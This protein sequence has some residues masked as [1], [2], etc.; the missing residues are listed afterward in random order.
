MIKFENI[1]KSYNGKV[2]CMC[3]CVGRYSVP[4]HTTLE[5]VAKAD[6][7]Q[8]AD[9]SNVSDRRVKLAVTKINQVLAMSEEERADNNVRL[10][11]DDAYVSVEIGARN[12]TVYLK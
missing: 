6:G 12:T 2:G 3:G 9:D 10:F 8:S 1:F 7:W 4:T 5:A 11:E